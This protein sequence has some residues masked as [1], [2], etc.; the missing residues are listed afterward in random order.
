MNTN[1][2]NSLAE[3]LYAIELEERLET[4][5]VAAE[6]AYVSCALDASEAAAVAAE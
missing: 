4:V 2:E 5:E 1:F 3:G 6:A